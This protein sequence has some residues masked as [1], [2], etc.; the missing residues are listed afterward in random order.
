MQNLAA[1][2]PL[3]AYFCDDRTNP[4]REGAVTSAL[5]QFIKDFRRPATTGGGGGRNRGGGAFNPSGLFN[6]VCQ[7]A[8]RFKG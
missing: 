6:A 2:V 3:S 1:L 7:I 5:R 8:P 4:G